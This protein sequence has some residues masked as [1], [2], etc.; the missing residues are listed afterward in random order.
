MVA[1]SNAPIVQSNQ[2]YD[3]EIKDVANYI[4]NY[5]IKS[6]VAVCFATDLWCIC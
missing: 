4:H 1:H 6:D 5:D 3:P 2:E